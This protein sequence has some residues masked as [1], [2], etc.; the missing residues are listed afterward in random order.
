M[1]NSAIHHPLLLRYERTVWERKREWRSEHLPLPVFREDLY[2]HHSHR[3]LCR[4]HLSGLTRDRKRERSRQ[5]DFDSF[6]FKSW[7]TTTPEDDRRSVHSKSVQQWLQHLLLCTSHPFHRSKFVS[8]VIIAIC[9]DYV[10]IAKPL[11]ARG[12][13]YESSCCAS[14]QQGCRHYSIW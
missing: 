1:W 5:S 10:A 11:F 2:H 3:M 9:P 7:C 13:S 4:M 12:N 14:Q 6:C 8:S